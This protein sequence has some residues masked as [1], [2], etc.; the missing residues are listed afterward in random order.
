MITMKIQRLKIKNFRSFTDFSLNLSG[1]SRFVI[2]ACA[3]GK[4]SLLTAIN[5][6]LGKDRGF[7]KADFGDLDETIEIEL[8]LS[9]LD[10]SQRATFCERIDFASNELTFG[11]RVTWD[12]ADENP[13]VEH[14]Y[15]TKGWNKSIVEEREALQAQWLPAERDVGKYLQFGSRRNLMSRLIEKIDIGSSVEDT[16]NKIKELADELGGIKQIEDLLAASRAEVAKMVPE[17]ADDLLAL[18]TTQVSDV[19]VL[20]LL[21]LLVAYHSDHVPVAEQSS[22]LG[23]LILFAF[24]IQLARTQPGTVLLIDQPELSLHP[25]PQRALARVL[26]SLPC[27]W[28]IATHSSNLLDRVDPRKIIRL[29]RDASG[30]SWAQPAGLSEA[31]AKRFARYTTPQ[32]AEA[33]FARSAVL[34]EGLSDLYAIVAAADKLSRDLDAEGISL[35]DMEGAGG[36]KTFINLLGPSGFGLKVA[37][38]CD[39]DKESDW[40]VVLH[41][42]GITSADNVGAMNS[43]GFFVCSLDLEDELVRAY[44]AKN[45]V[46][47]IE[48]E[49][50]A[51]A[52]KQFQ[53]QPSERSKTLDEQVRGFI[54]KKGRK[55]R[56]AP[57][58]VERLTKAQIPLPLQQVLSYA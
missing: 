30:V 43:K 58:I 54:Q 41:E 56:Y 20:R 52:F 31:D 55:V 18:S 23:Q 33:F 14:G 47:L 42:A 45:V 21:G 53:L 40:A 13:V 11:V 46:T 6:A 39:A 16:S 12:D 1:S 49:G 38:M 50:E 24:V 7:T 48:E 27:Q 22:G 28:L 57:L 10:A 29:K 37:G 26:H 35:V 51:N 15:P 19:E 36:I 17:V 44:G 9:D 25:Q 34:V 8:V 3:G 32:T 2:A 4:T 5:R